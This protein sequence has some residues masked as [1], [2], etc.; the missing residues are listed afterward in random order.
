MRPNALAGGERA[1][2]AVFENGGHLLLG[3]W[4]EAREA[5]DRFL[6]RNANRARGN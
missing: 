2:L 5:M 4:D 6:L 1:D 3:R